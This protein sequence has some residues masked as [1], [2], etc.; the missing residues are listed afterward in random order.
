MLNRG[1]G[2]EAERTISIQERQ[3]PICPRTLNR[4]EAQLGRDAAIGGKPAELAA[5][6]QYAMAGHDDRKRV[7][8]E[9]LPHGACGAWRTQPLCKFAVRQ[10]RPGGMVRATS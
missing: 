2:V 1:N 7:S 3:R 10:R 8:P 5:S 4:Q 9:R 6:R